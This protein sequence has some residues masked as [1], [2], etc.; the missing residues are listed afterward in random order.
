MP[1]KTLTLAATLSAVAVGSTFVAAQ[2]PAASTTIVGCVYQEKD[3]PG[4]A[5][6]LAERAGVLEDYILAEITPAEASK[7]VGTSGS[8]ATP[9]T[10]S[11]YKLELAKDSELKAMVGKRVEVMGRIDS[12][13]GDSTGQPPA[14]ATTSRTDRIMGRDKL[15]LPEFEVSSIRAIDGACPATPSS[16]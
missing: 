16:R 3:V 14:G 15:D 2:T 6:N 5:P 10:N 12:E 1:I 11:M 7:A 4:R 13:K 9:T 8:T